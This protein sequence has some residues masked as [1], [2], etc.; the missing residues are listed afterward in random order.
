MFPIALRICLIFIALVFIVMVIRNINQRKLLLQYSLSWLL[1]S[2]SMITVALFPQIASFLSDLVKIKEPSNFVYA[3]GLF[4]LLFMTFNFTGKVSKQTVM[5]R[6]L[7]QQEAI[8]RYF[9][10]EM[11]KNNSRSSN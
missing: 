4:V 10:E 11:Q 1:L 9:I 6:T 5:L 2:L 8:D 7:I 3:A